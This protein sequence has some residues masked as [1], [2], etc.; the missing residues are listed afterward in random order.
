MTFVRGAAFTGARARLSINN[1]FIG[2]ATGCDGNEQ[3]LRQA[4]RVLGSIYVAEH[5]PTGFD[6]AFSNSMARLVGKTLKSDGLWPK[7][8]PSSE[9][10]LREIL[11][12]DMGATIEDPVSGTVLYRIQRLA[13][14]TMGWSVTESGLS[15]KRCTWA[16]QKQLEESE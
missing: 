14:L 7:H 12:F 11:A 9:E 16:A 5:V 13:P 10:F 6:M 1:K 8:K 15:V 2:Y 3:I 4:L